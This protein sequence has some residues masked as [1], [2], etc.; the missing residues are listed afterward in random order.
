LKIWNQDIGAS[1]YRTG[2]SRENERAFDPPIDAG[3]LDWGFGTALVPPLEA[4]PLSAAPPD[5]R[6]VGHI[7]PGIAI[8]LRAY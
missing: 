7:S 2:C 4:A 1:H 8:T 5:N 6:H 3:G